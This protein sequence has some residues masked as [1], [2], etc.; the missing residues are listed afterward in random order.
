MLFRPTIKLRLV[1]DDRHHGNVAAAQVPQPPERPPAQP[2]QDP[3]P[4][5]DPVEPPPGDPNEDRPLRDP[6]PPGTDR[7]RL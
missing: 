5:K 1:G 2:I 6:V 7:P 3:Q 4:Y